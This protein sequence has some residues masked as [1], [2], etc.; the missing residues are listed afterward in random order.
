M[1]K[2]FVL[3]VLFFV[4]LG[5]MFLNFSKDIKVSS[6]K[7]KI[8]VQINEKYVGYNPDMSSY[9]NM[10]AFE[11]QFVGMHPKQFLSAIE[12]KD[13]KGIV[14]FGFKECHFCQE[15]TSYLNEA[16]KEYNLKVYYI[17]C[18]NKDFPLKDYYEEIKNKMSKNCL[19]GDDI[20]TPLVASVKNSTATKCHIGLSKKTNWQQNNPSQNAIEE[21]KNIYFNIFEEL[22]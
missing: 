14:F 7:E 13:F 3:L 16:A 8:N 20:S 6:R 12:D 2:I 22:R 11:H 4:L 15:A 19:N 18:Y 10:R 21:L 1:K 17:D 5:L 9:K